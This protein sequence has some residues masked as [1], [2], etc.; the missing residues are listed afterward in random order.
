MLGL[1]LEKS[2]LKSI[3]VMEISNQIISDFQEKLQ[4]I[5]SKKKDVLL[6]SDSVV[7]L[8][9]R[10]LSKLRRRILENGFKD[11]ASEIQFFKQ[12]KFL[13][14]S[15]LLY[16]DMVHS[17]ETYM[18]KMGFKVQKDYLVNKME[19]INTFFNT[20]AIF[21]NYLRLQRTDMDNLYFTRNNLEDG[22]PVSVS[23]LNYDPEFNSM[24]DVLLARV[25]ATYKFMEYINRALRELESGPEDLAF[26]GKQDKPLEYDGKSIDW[27]EVVYALH[28]GKVFKGD[29]QIIVIQRAV[30]RAFNVK[31]G[32]IHH[33]KQE[34]NSRIGERLTF[35]P[36]LLN[37]LLTR[38][39][40]RDGLNPNK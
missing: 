8:C 11:A 10:T 33:R 1:V 30:E 19:E 27:A 4:S 29:P 6:Q 36:F 31:I 7:K 26:K 5:E 25:E 35:L 13:P 37:V 16:Y 38:L 12:I 34:I 15:Q 20:N 21:V 22:L 23:G 2:H 17:C 24:Y 28:E 3:F 32:N 14:M 9:H 40:K 39:T 18:P